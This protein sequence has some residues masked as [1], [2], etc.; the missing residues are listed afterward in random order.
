MPG[1]L[2]GDHAVTSM[3]SPLGRGPDDDACS[4]RGHQRRPPVR[5]LLAA[6]GIA[7]D[8]DASNG[9]G[10]GV[11]AIRTPP[12]TLPLAALVGSR[13]TATVFWT[14]TSVDDR[15]RVADRTPLKVLHWEPT[16]PVTISV[17]ETAGTVT[18]RPGG[19][20]AI[21][22]QGYLRLPATV[23]HACRIRAGDR[24]LVGAYPDAAV[25]F[26]FT[27]AAVDAMVAA[28]HGGGALARTADGERP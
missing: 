10:P 11:T 9:G 12:Q 23:R 24:L 3:T 21:T 15:G 19:T 5:S 1:R 16:V 20:S 14:V 25:L 22:R 2:I 4:E 6:A 17:E 26:A 13:P 18:V 7:P 8:S 27:P 28:Y